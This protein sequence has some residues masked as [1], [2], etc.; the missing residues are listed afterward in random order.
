MNLSVVMSVYDGAATLDRTLDSIAAQ[1]ERDYELIVIDDG[2]RD[3]TPAIL[4]RR[5][6]G[7]AR[8]RVIGQQNTGLTR[9]LIRGCAEARGEFIARHDCGDQSMPERFA[10]QLAAFE[11][12]T[13]LVSCAMDYRAP[14]GEWLYCATGDGGEIRTSLL[15]DDARRIHGVA[16]GAAMFRRAAYTAAGGYRAEFRFA[17]DLDLWIRLA[18]LGTITVVPEALYTATFEPR[19][20]SGARRAEQVRLAE[21]AVRLRDARSDVERN[22]LLREAGLVGAAKV[23]TNVSEAP[24]LYFIASCLRRNGNQAWKRYAHAAIRA[25]PLHLRSWALLLYPLGR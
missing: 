19:A 6:A 15:R 9:A 13:V 2:S 16:H 18:P 20:I 25:N 11:A 8:I 7:D 24:A 4:A 3:D 14:G 21:I 17:Q 12:Q 22:E 5:A 1:T 23:T 10:K